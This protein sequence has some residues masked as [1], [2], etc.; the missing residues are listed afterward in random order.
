MSNLINKTKKVIKENKKPIIIGGSSIALLL[1]TNYIYKKGFIHGGKVGFHLTMD[2]F[3]RT[4]EGVEL[5]RLFEEW[6]QLNPDQI[7]K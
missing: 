1:Y 4:F 7:V 3:D 6:A 2:W 5:K